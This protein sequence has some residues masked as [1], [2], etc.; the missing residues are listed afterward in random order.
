MS[1][2][3]EFAGK[4][5]LVTGG[6]MGIGAAV[7]DLLAER[8]ARV[9]VVDRDA[10]AATDVASTLIGRG[11]E[12]RAIATDVSSGAEVSRCVAEIVDAWGQI[13]IVSNNAGIQRYGTVESTTESEWDEVIDVNLKSVYLVCHHAIPHLRKT[14]GAIV[15]MASVQSFATQRGVAAYT[16]GKHA[17]IGLTRSM[18]LDFAEYGVRVNAVAPGS[19]DTPM[20]RWAISL[21]ENPQALTEAIRDMHPLGRI[22]DPKEI[23]ETVCF[24][25]SPKAS[26]VTGSTLIADGGL[27]LPISGAPKD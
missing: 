21:D 17:L 20:L 13:D 5:A 25:A 27:L 1:D 14:R 4:V 7:C 10:V 3:K 19:V 8:S 18:A 23:A 11:L 9:A 26:F 24:L 12:A 16:T 2:E 22:A 15:N 6:A